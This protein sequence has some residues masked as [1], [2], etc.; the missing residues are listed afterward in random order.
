L[1][2][3]DY[4]SDDQIAQEAKKKVAQYPFATYI[5]T[6]TRGWFWNRAHALNIGIRHSQGDICLFYDIDLILEPVFLE[7]ISFFNYSDTYYTFSCFYLPE[8]FNLLTKDVLRDGIHYEQNYVG[9][10]AAGRKPVESIGGFDEFYMVWGVEDDDFYSRL[11]GRGLNRKQIAA[12]DCPVFHQWHPTHAPAK[13][14]AWYIAMVNYFFSKSKVENKLGN[15]GMHY[16]TADRPSLLLL[17]QYATQ[18]AY[19]LKFWEDNNLLFFN[20]FI[21][22]FHESAPGEILLVEY[23]VAKQQVGNGVVNKAIQIFRKQK[24]RKPTI[25]NKEITAFFQYFV[26]VNRGLIGDYYF[27]ISSHRLLFICKKT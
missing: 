4:G 13:P 7:K 16:H 26:G 1:V 15:W 3:I 5:Y 24:E 6:D 17:S 8:H 18:S 10:C 12:A 22:K 25:G 23:M 11:Q 21:Q 19:K 9:L 27:E 2:F 14:D 20:P